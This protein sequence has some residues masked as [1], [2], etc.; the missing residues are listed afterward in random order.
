MLV[1]WLAGWLVGF[2]MMYSTYYDLYIPPSR[3]SLSLF[4][5]PFFFSFCFPFFHVGVGFVQ[6]QIQSFFFLFRE[7]V[8]L[9]RKKNFVA[10]CGW[11][12]GHHSAAFE[13]TA[14][15]AMQLSS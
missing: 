10:C 11:V 5:F 14:A 12:M 13:W 7:G 3:P 2:S 15:E 9:P 6:C 1:S 8:V 4:L